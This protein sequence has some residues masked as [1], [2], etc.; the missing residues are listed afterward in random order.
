MGKETNYKYN[1]KYNECWHLNLKTDQRSL[2]LDED[3]SIKFEYQ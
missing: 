3:S 2:I 1:Y